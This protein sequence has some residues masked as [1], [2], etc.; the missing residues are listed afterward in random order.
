MITLTCFFLILPFFFFERQRQMVKKPFFRCFRGKIEYSRS[1]LFS[2][3]WLRPS[4]FEAF[5]ADFES[6]KVTPRGLFCV[7]VPCVLPKDSQRN[8]W[9]PNAV[10]R[11]SRGLQVSTNTTESHNFTPTSTVQLQKYPEPSN[12]IRSRLYCVLLVTGRSL[13]V[14]ATVP[15]V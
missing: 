6:H 15:S 10:S 8:P 3:P 2:I 11:C 12:P 9:F 1:L 4:V 14:Y 13:L 5:V 7:Y